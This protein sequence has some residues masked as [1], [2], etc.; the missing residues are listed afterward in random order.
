MKKL[1]DVGCSTFISRNLPLH[2]HPV[3]NSQPLYRTKRLPSRTRLPPEP[4]GALPPLLSW[5][6]ITS[7]GKGG[8]RPLGNVYCPPKNT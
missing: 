5:N 7:Y 4:A 3:M 1:L 8:I 6:R 2:K